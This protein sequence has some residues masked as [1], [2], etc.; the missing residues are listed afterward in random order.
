MTCPD[1]PVDQEI[2]AVFAI[3]GDRV[4][5][6]EYYRVGFNGVTRIEKT[7]KCGSMAAMPYVRIWKGDVAVAEF[8]QHQIIGVYYEEP[9]EPDSKEAA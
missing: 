9:K 4:R 2:D 3:E 5:H 1:W 8:C 7:F 6:D